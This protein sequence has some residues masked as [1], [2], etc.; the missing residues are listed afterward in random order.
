MRARVPATLNLSAVPPVEPTYR[1]YIGSGAI[2]LETAHVR[3]HALHHRRHPLWRAPA[4]PQ[5]AAHHLA[6]IG[7]AIGLAGAFAASATV[8]LLIAVLSSYLPARRALRVDPT[9][10][11]RTE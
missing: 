6:A 5:P 4:P 2:R 9:V 10:A 8:L 7:V 11:M 3:R 1:C